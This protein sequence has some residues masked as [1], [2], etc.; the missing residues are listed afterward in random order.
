LKWLWQRSFD[1]EDQKSWINANQPP[2]RTWGADH[3]QEVPILDF[4]DVMKDDD[5]LLQWLLHLEVLGI[6]LLGQVPEKLGQVGVLANRVGF[7]R[8]THYG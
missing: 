8:K 1:K 2:Y 5:S 4:N 3:F 7:I 6:C